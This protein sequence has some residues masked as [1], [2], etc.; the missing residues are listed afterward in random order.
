M[1]K[2][3]IGFGALLLASAAVP[4]LAQ[5]SNRDASGYSGGFRSYDLNVVRQHVRDCRQHEQFH[6]E[7][8][9]AH[10]Q[11]HAEGVAN[12][13]DHHDAHDELQSAHDQ[14][15]DEHGGTENCEYWNNRL[16]E[17]QNRGYN[18][19]N[20]IR[21]PVRDCRQHE[22]FHQELAGAHDQQHAEGV[23]NGQDHHDVHDELQSAHDQ[24]H[25]DNGSVQNCDYWYN[26]NARLQ[27]N[28]NPYRNRYRSQSPYYGR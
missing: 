26:Q 13:Q 20:E 2:F 17:L 11:Q 16:T 14:Y 4:A 15:H 19:P 21:Q 1:N 9:D 7:L 18:D 27:N 24:Y 25:E 22:Q 6:Q 5:Y 23:A 28:R 3:I 12:G 10:D 8:A